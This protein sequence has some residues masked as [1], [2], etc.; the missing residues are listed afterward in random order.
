MEILSPYG[1]FEFRFRNYK[2]DTLRADVYNIDETLYRA[3][4][5][6]YNTKINTQELTFIYGYSHS[7][8]IIYFDCHFAFG[9]GLKI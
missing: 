1:G 2:I 8:G 7:K 9:F 4:T 3:N 6:L 5:T